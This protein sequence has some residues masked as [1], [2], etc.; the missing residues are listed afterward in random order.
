MGNIDDGHY[1]SYAY[2]NN[3]KRWIFF[4]DDEFGI[5]DNEADVGLSYES[6]C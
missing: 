3:L 2:N 5:L 1:L 4:D 6:G